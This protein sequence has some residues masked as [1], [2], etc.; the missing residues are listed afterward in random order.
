MSA[1]KN[2]HRLSPPFVT[3]F[4][5]HRLSRKTLTPLGAFY[6][7]HRHPSSNDR[8]ASSLRRSSTRKLSRRTYLASGHVLLGA[9]LR[10]TNATA[11][12]ESVPCVFAG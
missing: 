9:A 4:C 12:V 3:T 2:H 1:L 8:R 11:N 6:C 5:H 10:R 7:A